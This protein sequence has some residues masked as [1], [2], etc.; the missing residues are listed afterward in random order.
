MREP[1]SIVDP[2][3]RVISSADASPPGD[4]RPS[5]PALRPLQ[6]LD[7]WGNETLG[8]NTV[9][10]PLRDTYYHGQAER[11]AAE[12]DELYSSNGLAR[13]IID[14][15]V[16]DAT[17]KW[18]TFSGIEGAPLVALETELARLKV[19]QACAEARKWARLYGGGGIVVRVEGD[20][21]SLDQPLDPRKLRRIRALEVADRHDLTP[22]AVDYLRAYNAEPDL[23]YWTTT[24]GTSRTVHRSRVI[25]FEGLPVPRRRKALYQGWG[26]SVIDVVWDE[27]QNVGITHQGLARLAS[28]FRTLALKL[29]DLIGQLSQDGEAVV[30]RRYSILRSMQS[31]FRMTLLDGQ[32]SLESHSATVG[33]LSDVVYQL[34]TALSAVTHIPMVKLWGTSPGGLNAS[35]ETDIT[36][37]YDFVASERETYLEPPLG[38]LL[39]LVLA[40]AVWGRATKLTP[41]PLRDVADDAWSWEFAPLREMSE[42]DRADLRLKTSQADA[43]DINAGVLDPAE[44]A[45]SR[46]GGGTYSTETHIDVEAR[47][48]PE[49]EDMSEPEGPEDEPPDGEDMSEPEED[50]EASAENAQDAETY[51]APAAVANAA[52]RALAAREKAPP[53]RRGMT[54]T[55]LAR[56]RQLAEGEG[57]SAD[58]LERMVAFFSRHRG[59]LPEGGLI[60]EDGIW[61]KWKQA[62]EGWGGMP[63]FRW[64]VGVLIK[65]APT[66]TRKADLRTLRRDV[67][68][69]AAAHI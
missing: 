1:P 40:Q 53:S 28:E 31:I 19:K 56:A 26:Q 23:Y 48:V 51:R 36:F 47:E 52:K 34:H 8:H 45:L 4:S 12:L 46:Y 5:P 61:S 65:L 63:G 35:G 22:A 25:R 54:A 62:W 10:D 32:E 39:D 43:I 37:Y 20:D 3:G 49:N 33:G 69:W 66:D 15:P 24:W 41:N 2:H 18:I 59:T 38:E 6:I 11:P 64:A 16:D 42:A 30:E 7:R 50:P 29:P 17:R 27:L 21:N 57:V 60:D 9:R 44:V 67:Q 14:I 55:G 13:K 68:T 58:T